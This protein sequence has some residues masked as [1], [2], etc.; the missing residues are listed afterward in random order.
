MSTIE[1]I[2]K[3]IQYLKMELIH[4]SHFC[5]IKIVKSNLFVVN[6]KQLNFFIFQFKK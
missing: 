1:E 3:E 6:N 4:F 2:N 5:I